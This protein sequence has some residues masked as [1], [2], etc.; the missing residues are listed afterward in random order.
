MR[1][2]LELI[3]AL[4]ELAASFSGMADDTAV[5]LVVAHAP[6]EAR[7][8]KWRGMADWRVALIFA[9]PLDTSDRLERLNRVI[10]AGGVPMGHVVQL[11]DWVTAQDA[12]YRALA[13]RLPEICEPDYN[14]EWVDEFLKGCCAEV[15]NKL[16]EVTGATV[17]G[18]GSAA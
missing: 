4:D 14:E 15:R 8:P 7:D 2:T 16:L 5:A 10:A 17:F 13:Q 3:Q 6:A 12:R 11:R 1:T 18:K 9:A